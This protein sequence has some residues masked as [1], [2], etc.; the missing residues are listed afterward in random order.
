[1]KQDLRYP[2]PVLPTWI[3]YS[4]ISTYLSCPYKALL[5]YGL[6]I[7]KDTTALE[8]TFGGSIHFALELSYQWWAKNPEATVRQLR[9]TAFHAFRAYWDAFATDFAHS[10]DEAIFPR[11]PGNA[12]SMLSS[13]F[14]THYKHDKEM[15]LVGVEIPIQFLFT[16]PNQD[17]SRPNHSITYRGRIDRVMSNEAGRIHAYEI[18]TSSIMSDVIFFGYEQSYQSD[19]YLRFLDSFDHKKKDAPILEYDILAVKKTGTECLRRP[20]LKLASQVEA[21]FASLSS[22]ITRI[23]Q[24]WQHLLLMIEHN[25]SILFD[26]Q[27]LLPVFLRSKGTACTEYMRKC[28]YDDICS[29]RAN[30][31]TYLAGI[32]TGYTHRPWDPHLHEQMVSSTLLHVTQEILGTP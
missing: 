11:S 22:W 23:H 13:Y 31:L 14:Q 7:R 21:S 2:L 32:P 30:P 10:P 15:T 27:L 17:P 4:T 5:Q 24:D 20:I 18:K 1:M 9:D 8:L 26:R 19:G 3:D 12:L 16:M 6:H 25:P 29:A 28:P